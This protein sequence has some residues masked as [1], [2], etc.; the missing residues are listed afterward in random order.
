MLISAL[1]VLLG[2][3]GIALIVFGIYGIVRGKYGE[4]TSGGALGGTIAIPLSGLILILGLGSLAYAGYLALNGTKQEPGATP[5]N[6]PGS[7]ITSLPIISPTAPVPS[8]ESPTVTTPATVSSMKLTCSLS[9]KRL[10]PGM[11]VQ[12]TYHVDSPAAR[13]V[14]LGAGLYD[15][16]GNDDSNGNGDIAS[17]SLQEGWNS[18][19]RPVTIPANL[20]PG[21]YE[22]D[23]EIWPANE[24]GQDGV[25]DLIDTTCTYFNVP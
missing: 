14:G 23:A 7:P 22:L 19:S 9:Q 17:M 18:P 4:T 8:T 20:A 10:R 13:Q 15:E 25:N 12:L 1:V 6:I 2:L 11:T 24:I 5:T 16:Q 3:A 21:Q